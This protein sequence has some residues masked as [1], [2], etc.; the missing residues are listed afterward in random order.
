MARVA[1]L[2]EDFVEEV[3]FIYPFYRFKEE[4]FQVDVLA[5]RSGSFRGKKGLSF[6]ANGKVN[7]ERAPDYDCV[8][9]PGGY[10]PDRLR[11]SVKVLEFV[12]NAFNNGKLVAA[13]CHGPWVLISA[14]IVKGKKVTGFF[15]IRDDLENAGAVYT[16]SPVEVDGNLVTATDPSAM[17]AMLKLIVERLKGSGN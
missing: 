9:I 7:P 12:R 15:S 16:G 4:G 13:I 10:A 5:P 8:F 17:P 3:E 11:R 2:L 14:G 1:I 6:E